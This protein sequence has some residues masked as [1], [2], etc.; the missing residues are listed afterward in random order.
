MGHGGLHRTC[1]WDI[2][3]L[4]LRGNTFPTKY[5]LIKTEFASRNP[6]IVSLSAVLCLFK[7]SSYWVNDQ[8]FRGNAYGGSW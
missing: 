3:H 4:M 8:H 1:G 6:K 5:N 2:S 7:V